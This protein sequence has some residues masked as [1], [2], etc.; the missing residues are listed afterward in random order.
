MHQLFTPSAELKIAEPTWQRH[1][2]EMRLPALQPDVL[3]QG[4]VADG[5]GAKGEAAQRGGW[6]RAGPQR[7]QQAQRAQLRDRAPQGVAGRGKGRRAGTLWLGL[8]L[9]SFAI[10]PDSRQ[11]V[12]AMGASDHVCLDEYNNPT[13]STAG[14]P[15]PAQHE[16]EALP[17]RMHPER[18]N[19]H[20]FC[21]AEETAVHRWPLHRRWSSW[22]ARRTCWCCCCCCRRAAAFASAVAAAAAFALTTAVAHIAASWCALAPQQ[23]SQQ[24]GIS[25]VVARVLAAHECNVQ[26]GGGP[27]QQV[28]ASVW[29]RCE[30]PVVS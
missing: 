17:P 28:P 6:R 9:P 14:F 21:P 7:M 30:A 8:V 23:A 29:Q 18:F 15:S 20:S 1:T 10:F 5:R 16:A 12:Q 13:H 25:K 22:H 3:C 2:E 26:R 24:V 11:A 27:R 4:S 19:H